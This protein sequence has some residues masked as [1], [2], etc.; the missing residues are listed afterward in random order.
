MVT[1][2]RKQ[3]YLEADQ[4]SRLKFL[5]ERFDIT[6]AEIIRTAIDRQLSQFIPPRLNFAKWKAEA[7][8]I[9]SLIALG[10]VTGGRTWQ[11]EDLY[12]R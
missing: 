5:T 7:D 11:R 6:E 8:F 2:V 4:E 9:Q 10:P 12:E 3:I 1:K